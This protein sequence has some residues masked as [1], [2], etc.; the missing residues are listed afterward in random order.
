MLMAL[1]RLVEVIT[2]Y[3]DVPALRVLLGAVA[4]DR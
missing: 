1:S 3:E 2:P 4:T